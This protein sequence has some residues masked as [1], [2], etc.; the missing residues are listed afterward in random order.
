MRSTPPPRR[1]VRPKPRPPLSPHEL[2]H[3]SQEHKRLIVELAE[4]VRDLS[5]FLREMNLLLALH[6][7]QR[8]YQ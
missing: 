3:Y 2:L 6:K 5:A 8:Y 1:N 4:A 7:R